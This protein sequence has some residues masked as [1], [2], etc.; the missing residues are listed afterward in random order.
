[1]MSQGRASLG[2]DRRHHLVL[3]VHGMGP[4][5]TGRRNSDPPRLTHD[6]RKDGGRRTG[7]GSWGVMSLRDS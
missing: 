4:L 5:G 2:S 1:M 3:V 6:H 7:E